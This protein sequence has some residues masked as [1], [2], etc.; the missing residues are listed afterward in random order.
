MLLSFAAALCLIC[1]A[2]PA[3]GQDYEAMSANLEAS[4]A[5]A[6]AQAYR[7]GD[8]ALTCDELESEFV[9]VMQDPQLQAAFAARG[10]WAQTQQQRMNEAQGRA[11]AQIAAS[12]FM[13]V[14]SAFVP[15][16]GYAQMAQQRLQAADM[17]RRQQSNLAEMMA[18]AERM[19]AIMPQTM[20]G[21]RLYELAQA[22][23]CTF[24]QEQ[25][26]Q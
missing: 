11:R 10:E 1:A 3:T 7:E 20:R 21:Q 8:E 22:G 13:G 24:V 9:A 5:A 4:M 15:G 26:P 17:Q 23:Q 25:P 6:E 14:A 18:M 12:M 16:L 2:A 19:S